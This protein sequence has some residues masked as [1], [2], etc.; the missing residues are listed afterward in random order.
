MSASPSVT[1]AAV[2]TF[3]AVLCAVTLNACAESGDGPGVEPVADLAPA[4]GAADVF[5]ARDF[6]WSLARGSG[7]IEGALAYRQGAVRFTCEGSDVLLTPETA[8][9][10][11][12]MIIL[13]GS[14][15]AAA[16]PVT[17]VKARV[18]SAPTGDYVRFV[19]RTTCDQTNHFT[20]S[21]LPDGSWF[22]ITVGKP[23]DGAGEA[24][25]VLRRVDTHGGSNVAILS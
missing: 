17:I 6:A 24:V 18:P 4:R 3:A 19:R 2:G 25:A 5:D 12:R 15:R 16:A 20:F 9:S 11:R 10:R 14:A 1:R 22:V 7:S 13:Y 8:W 23:V 21:G